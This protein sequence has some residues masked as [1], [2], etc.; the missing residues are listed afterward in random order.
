MVITEKPVKLAT[1]KVNV[2]ERSTKMAV[3]NSGGGGDKGTGGAV[4]QVVVVATIRGEVERFTRG[5]GV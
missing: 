1:L 2:D 5:V 3:I 4:E